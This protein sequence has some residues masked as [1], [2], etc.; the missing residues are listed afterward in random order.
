MIGNACRV[1]P[2]RSQLVAP[3][4]RGELIVEGADGL[5]P[6]KARVVDRHRRVFGCTA[7]SSR[8]SHT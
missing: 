2:E 5:P 3:R 4:H 7:K 8:E 6:L 1:D